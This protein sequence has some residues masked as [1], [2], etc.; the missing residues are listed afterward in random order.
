M[1]KI[2]NMYFNYINKN[3]IIQVEGGKK[4]DDRY[5]RQIGKWE[6]YVS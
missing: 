1:I 2:N 6:E 5:L 3:Y 4:Y